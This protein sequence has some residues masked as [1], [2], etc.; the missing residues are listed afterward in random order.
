M[1]EEH[2]DEIIQKP[3]K[4]RSEKQLLAFEKAREKRVENAKIKKEK[5]NEIK[6]KAKKMQLIDESKVSSQ[7]I[8]AVTTEPESEPVTPAKPVIKKQ[9]KKPNTTI[10]YQSDSS[11]TDEEIVIVKKK[12]EKKPQIPEPVISKIPVIKFI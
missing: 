6:E 1:E 10:I 9:K 12:R 3:K 5:I 2:L 8:Q 11:D 4:P 7:P